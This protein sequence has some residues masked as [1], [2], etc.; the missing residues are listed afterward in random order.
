MNSLDGFVGALLIQVM[1]PHRYTVE[2]ALNQLGLHA[3][4]EIILFQ[5]WANDGLTQSEIA[6]LVDVTSP[7]ISKMLRG[8]ARTD[9]IQRREDLEDGRISRVFLTEKGRNLQGEVTR[10]WQDVEQQMMHSV[11]EVEKIV[12]T[13]LLTQMR[14]NL[15]RKG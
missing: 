15:Q 4:Q 12:L 9:L 10:I 5:L 3:G 7:T 1:R 2:A 8:L 13:R 6:E 11:N 14:D